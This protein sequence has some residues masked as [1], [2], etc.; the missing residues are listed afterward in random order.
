MGNTNNANY[1]WELISNGTTSGGTWTSFSADS[2]VD[3]NVTGTTITGGNVL[4]SGYLSSSALSSAST[5]VL[6]AALF[7]FQLERNSFTS[8]PYEMTLAVK[9]STANATVFTALSFEEISR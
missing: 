3:Y 7:S 9:S 5:D 2:S 1:S 4:T 6:R 8:T